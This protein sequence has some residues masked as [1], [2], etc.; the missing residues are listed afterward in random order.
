MARMYPPTWRQHGEG[1]ERFI[2]EQ[3]REH[4]GR[5]YTVLHSVDWV[6]R[7]GS[8][9]YDGEADFVIAHPEFGVLILEVKGGG[10]SRVGDAWW[11]T[12]SAGNRH[13]VE[14]GPF[15]QA[16]NSL[17]GI[18]RKLGTAPASRRFVPYPMARA[19][20]FPNATAAEA[21][22]GPEAVREMI[23]DE[24]D[25]WTLASAIR[26]AFATPFTPGRAPGEE[27]VAALLEALLPSYE[28]RHTPLSLVEEGRHID[29]EIIRL[30]EEQRRYLTFLGERRRAAICGPAGSGKTMLAMEQCRRLAR[31]GFRVL[32]TC[33]NLGLAAMVRER[34]A[35]DVAG[36]RRRWW[37]PPIMTWRAT[38]PAAPTSRCR[39]SLRTGDPATSGCTRRSCP[40]SSTP[41]S[42]AC[43][44][45]S[46]RSSSTRG[47]TSRSSG[48]NRSGVCSPIAI[49][50]SSSSMTTA[51]ACSPPRDGC[52]SRTSRSA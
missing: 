43:P 30:T 8:R 38:S 47:R 20:A 45:G 35:R 9:C 32:F 49:G 21:W 22:Y 42:S 29:A 31:R 34:L 11:S 24:R 2:Y 6:D 23:I 41:P 37:W 10:I 16:K 15:D 50:A 33:F 44:T 40:S 14:P 36:G 46:T 12:D 26:R 28:L 18:A 13:P 4:L 51:S 17:Y 7:R 27:G 1:S 39:T 52:R 19:V 5:S 25:R 3:L 48:G